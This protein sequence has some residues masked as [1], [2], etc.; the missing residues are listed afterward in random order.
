MIG[1]NHWRG[2]KVKRSYPQPQ[3]TELRFYSQINI[4]IIQMIYIRTVVVIC[5][6]IITMI[7]VSSSWSTNT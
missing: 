5:V 4:V 7:R 1:M 3:E 2:L 6:A